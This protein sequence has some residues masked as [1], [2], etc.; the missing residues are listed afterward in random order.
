MKLE[1][2]EAM[3]SDCAKS[4]SGGDKLGYYA[5]EVGGLPWKDFGRA[6]GAHPSQ[7]NS[8][9]SMS[10]YPLGYRDEW[11]RWILNRVG[12]TENDLFGFAGVDF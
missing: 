2:S 7:N 6:M 5:V 4:E 9:H 3:C 8:Q 10:I 1:R 11:L 12:R